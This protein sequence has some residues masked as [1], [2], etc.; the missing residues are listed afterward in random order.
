MV[1][2]LPTDT[3]LNPTRCTVAWYLQMY[4]DGYYSCPTPVR[5]AYTIGRNVIHVTESVPSTNES[6][7]TGHG[8]AGVF[9]PRDF[10]WVHKI[11]FRV[12]IYGPTSVPLRWVV[13]FASLPK[14]NWEKER[15]RESENLGHPSNAQQK[16]EQKVIKSPFVG[17]YNP[18]CRRKSQKKAAWIPCKEK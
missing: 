3:G 9:S 8:V 1:S 2:F 12:N 7:I 10:G 6:L 16:R 17:S 5:D 15:E 13:S 14:E 18:S 4:S 11:H